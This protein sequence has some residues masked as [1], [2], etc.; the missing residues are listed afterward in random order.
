MYS[1]GILVRILYFK[2][3]PEKKQYNNI[4]EKIDASSFPSMHASRATILLI[5]LSTYFNFELKITTFLTLIWGTI[6]YARIH[7]KRHDYKDIIGGTLLGIIT[8]SL[9]YFI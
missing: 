1:I 3:R 7:K 6:L 8:F 5:T 9:V 4:L 2:E